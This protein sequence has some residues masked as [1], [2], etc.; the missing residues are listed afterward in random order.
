MKE[1]PGSSETSVL[2]RATRRNNPEDTILDTP[3]TCALCKGNHPANYKGCSVYRELLNAKNKRTPRRS[4]VQTSRY[5]NDT[6][7]NIPHEVNTQ[8]SNHNNVPTYAQVA[9]PNRNSNNNN[10]DNKFSS[11][12]LEFKNMFSQ[13]LNQNSMILTMLTTVI[14]KLAK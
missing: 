6:H 1:A 14:S 5:K 9:S 12:L 8:N 4:N 7:I 13:L 3:A 10:L 11:F 2:T